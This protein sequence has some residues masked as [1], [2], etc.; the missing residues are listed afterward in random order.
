MEYSTAQRT[1]RVLGA[2]ATLAGVRRSTDS[3]DK[4]GEPAVIDVAQSAP[5]F[6]LESADG[7]GWSLFAAAEQNAAL[8]AF[9]SLEC[10]ACDISYLFWDRM[11]EQYA[12]SGCPVVAISVD[13]QD[14]AF[15]FYERSGVSFPVLA[16][17]DHATARAYGIDVTPSLFLV[18][19][20]G[21]VISAHTAFD[22][23]ALNDLSA[24]IAARTG[25]EPVSLGDGEAP[26]FSP[27]CV[28]HA[29]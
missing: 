28:W 8:V 17:P 23:Q 29:D 20:A 7:A 4:R 2:Y 15:D 21:T 27:G 12:D 5:A 14:Q 13:T 25:A 3:R 26:A 16:D 22:R 11:H 24:E 19:A 9:F 1:T 6:A 18:D 10:R